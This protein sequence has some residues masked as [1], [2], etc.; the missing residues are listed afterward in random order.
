MR[1]KNTRK[2]EKDKL[3]ETDRTGFTVLDNSCQAFLAD[4]ALN[5]LEISGPHPKLPHDKLEV[6]TNKR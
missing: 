1:G 3:F 4:N 6:T 2:I 5:K